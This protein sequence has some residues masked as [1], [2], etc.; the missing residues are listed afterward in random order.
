MTTD[1]TDERWPRRHCRLVGRRPGPG[2]PVADEPVD[3]ETVPPDP[4][5]AL[6]NTGWRNQQLNRFDRI[7]E[8]AALALSAMTSRRPPRL[9]WVTINTT[10]GP[11]GRPVLVGELQGYG[12]IT[13]EYAQHLLRTGAATEP[14]RPSGR[15]PTSSKPT[16]TTHPA[17][18][19]TRSR[20]ATAPAGSPAA[21]NPPTEST[22]TTSSRSHTDSPCAPTSAGSA[23][24]TTASRAPP[25]GTWR[26]ATTAPTSGPPRSPDAATPPTHAAPPANGAAPP[27]TSSGYAGT[28]S[29]VPH[30]CGSP[31]DKPTQ[32]SSTLGRRCRRHGA[33]TQRFPG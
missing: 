14:P 33:P 5:Q 27:A 23:D 4:A 16:P 13:S 15:E 32:P 6:V 18:S 28:D 3:P 26:S 11:D 10:T 19:P 30:R 21:D 17:G 2:H 29:A 12:P 24:A 25:G 1:D 31:P 20:P 8:L 22:S 9:P 7:S